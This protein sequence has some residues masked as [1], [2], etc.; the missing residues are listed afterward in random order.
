M[1]AIAMINQ[2]GGVGKTTTAVSIAAGLARLD[3]RVALVD[4]DP[5]SHASMSV[6][7]DPDDGKPTLYD[8]LARGAKLSETIRA[9][10]KKLRVIPGSLDLA[11]LEAELVDQPQ[12]ELRLRQTLAPIAKV[13]DAMII[14]CPPSLGLLSIN[15]L[16]AVDEVIIPLQ[17]HFLALQGLGK[18]LE[19]VTL[20]RDNLNPRLR[21]S[22]VVFCMYD[23]GAKLSQEVRNDVE[24][25][26]GDAEPDDPWN[27]AVIL[28]TVVRRNIKLAEAP[29]FGQTIF[30]YAADSNGA[31]DYAL[32]AREIFAM[33]ATPT[34][35]EIEQELG[36][37]DRAY[38]MDDDAVVD[39]VSKSA[40]ART[41]LGDARDA[42][43]PLPSV[44]VD[45]APRVIPSV[46]A[47]RESN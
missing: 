39:I 42:L 34:P 4:L 13:F 17:P 1:R 32:L 20:V 47:E 18:L 35:D 46:P 5:Q 31:A 40:S 11:A 30:D 2:K 23:R 29:S 15:A 12:R 44:D 45:S 28:S 43:D 38:A 24:A 16:A 8:V 6:G 10:G 27:G 21:V 7:V 3:Q 9:V 26:L 19:T 25:F 22:G 33:G 14:D 37:A 41:S 36:S